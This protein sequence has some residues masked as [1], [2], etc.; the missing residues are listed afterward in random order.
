ME[1]F[2]NAGNGVISGDNYATQ[3]TISDVIIA[4]HK[5]QFMTEQYGTIMTTAGETVLFFTHCFPVHNR[6]F[7][8]P[9]RNIHQ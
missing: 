8:I 1:L 5:E 6:A 7:F 2:K 3:I 4:Q 9:E